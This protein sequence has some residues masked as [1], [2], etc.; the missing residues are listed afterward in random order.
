MAVGNGFTVTVCTA[1]QPVAVSEY[2]ITAVCAVAG[3]TIAP[4][5]TKP[6]T[7]VATVELLVLH[8]PPGVISLNCV[9][10]PE[11]TEGMP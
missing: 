1:V 8:T 4:P 5:V 7:T 9:V 2:V 6:V 11:H 10:N 3:Y